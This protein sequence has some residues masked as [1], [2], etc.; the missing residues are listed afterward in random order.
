MTLPEHFKE[1]VE[2]ECSRHGSSVSIDSLQGQRY[3]QEY[4][5]GSTQ[6]HTHSFPASQSGKYTPIKP[7]KSRPQVVSHP[8]PFKFFARGERGRMYT[9][10]TMQ[11]CTLKCG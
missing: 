2:D 7:L 10:D 6:D 5:F 11:R 4:S 1:V 8:R 3:C 9:G